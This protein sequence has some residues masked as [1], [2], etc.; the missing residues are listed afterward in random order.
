MYQQQIVNTRNRILSQNIMVSMDSENKTHR[1]HNILVIGGSGSGKTF[2]FVK[3][4]LM[5]LSSSFIITDPKGEICRDTAEFMKMHGYDVKVINL[6]G[7]NKSNRY[8]PFKYVQ[9]DADILKLIQNLIR[10]TTP[11]GASSNDPF[12]EKAEAMLLQSVFYYV[13]REGVPNENTG[14][15][16]HN[17]GAVLKLL[18]KAEFEEDNNGNKKPSELDYMMQELE[19]KDPLHPAVVNYNKVMKGAADTVRSILMTANARLAPVQ[20]QSVIDFMSEDEMDIVSIG[21]K[22]TAVYCIIPDVDKTFNFLIG[23]FYTQCFQQLYYA[24]DFVYGGKLPVHVTFMLDEFAN[25][26]LPDDFT[27][28]LS[29]MRSREISAIPIIQNMAQ[30]KKIFKDDYETIQGNCDYTI[31]LGGNESGTHKEISESIGKQT[32]YKTSHGRTL[33]KNGS[34][35]TNEDTL[36]RELMM[37]SE[38]RTMKRNE[39]IILINGFNAIKDK[40]YETWNHPLFKELSRCKNFSFDARIE[41]AKKKMVIQR[42]GRDDEIDN[43]ELK[44]LEKEDEMNMTEYNTQM[45]IYNMTQEGDEPVLP[46]KNV[47]ELGFN[48]L[49]S[50]DID[51][52]D[53]ENIVDQLNEFISNR[54]IESNASAI[55]REIKETE[56]EEYNNNIDIKKEIHNSDEMK[57]ILKL[58]KEGYEVPQ[59][60]LLIELMRQNKAFNIDMICEYFSP[61]MEIETMKD[62]IE[63]LTV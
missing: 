53:D 44:L 57:L 55:N 24:A 61:D 5:Q 16:E 1:N 8:N 7:F 3:P 36:G 33:G 25:V 63:V 39:C 50:L 54:E 46:D 60:R 49:M 41:R 11:K 23:L 59:Q 4:N 13:W 43:S 26:S 29:T 52:L 31:F 48:E 10:N 14:I 37:P 22:K 6:L 2:R 15:K 21:T 35:S 27:N 19:E 58:S 38:V 56:E 51:S 47:I 9:E 20:T 28:L 30:L 42:F 32:I 12:W 18:E 17:I 62:S 45:K 40:K 34:S